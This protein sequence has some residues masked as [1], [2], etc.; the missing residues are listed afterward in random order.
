MPEP[1]TRERVR[2][3]QLVAQDAV[4]DVVKNPARS[5]SGRQG[6]ALDARIRTDPQ[7]RALAVGGRAAQAVTPGERRL[8]PGDRHGVRLH[9]RDSHWTQH[10]SYVCRMSNDVERMYLI[11]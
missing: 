8:R 1:L 9:V 2:A 7:D 3:D 11:S 4:D 5:A 6:D 10:T